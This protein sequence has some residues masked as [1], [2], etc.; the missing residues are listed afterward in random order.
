L[1]LI[2]LFFYNLNKIEMTLNFS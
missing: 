1:L 2:F